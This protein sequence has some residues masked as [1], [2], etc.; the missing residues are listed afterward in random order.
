MLHNRLLNDRY[1]VKEMIGG[2]GMA[3]VYLAQ[4]TILE[5]EVAIKVL[6]LE[7]GND[8]EFIARFHREAQSAISL[9]HPNI[10]NI[11]DVGEE[12]DI[13][14]M[15]MEYVD[16][17]TLKKYIQQNGPVEVSEALQIM[18]QITSAISHA[19]DNGI[20]HRDIKPENILID[21]YGQVKV[22]DFGIAMAL[23]ATALT[24]TNSI[25][26]SVHYL[27]PEQARGG[28]A[29]KKSDIYSLGIVMF[30]L[31]TGRLPFSGQ[32]AVSVALKH[33]Q[34]D[35]PSLRRWN[36]DIPQT[37][38]NAVLKATAKDPFHRYETV[39][40][41][42]MDLE[43]ALDPERFD[44]EPFTLP[45]DDDMEK[46]KA[47]P[48]I[49]QEA[50]ENHKTDKTIIH[51]NGG[52][53][54]K[55]GET[56]SP[57]DKKKEKKKKKKLLPWLLSIL[58]ILIIGGVAA[59]FIVPE[60]MK[61]DDVEMIDVTG[62]EYEEAYSELLK[63]NLDVER[64]QRYSE[65]VEEGIVIS[66]QPEE[67]SVIKEGKTVTVITSQGKEKV[68][69]E[70]YTGSDFEKTKSELEALGFESIT[71][72]PVSSSEVE[73]GMII[74]HGSPL[75][76]AEVVPEDTRVFFRV[77]TGPPYVELE[78]LIGMSQD[79]AVAALKD[80]NL[81][82]EITE[83]FSDEVEKGYVIRHEP[84]ENEDV[85][86]GSTVEL[87]VSKGQEK[88]PPVTVQREVTIPYD[89]PEQDNGDGQDG[90]GDEDTPPE[91]QEPVEQE[92]L[93]YIGDME[94]NIENVKDQFTITE[95]RT[96]QMTFLIAQN[97]EAAYRIVVDGETVLEDTIPYQE[98][99]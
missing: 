6:R 83:E 39:H 21:H 79:E 60:M 19:H 73:E 91:E 64:E 72:I 27:S 31:L 1:R 90:E 33:L 53:T 88:K 94:N 16:G 54:K 52:S 9:A 14:Y 12:E 15:V 11:F 77:S 98:G 74:E 35:T 81:N 87:V 82:E 78:S 69:F 22:T 70:D 38:E 18:S 42:E 56:N 10:V 84:G 50:F 26:G 89:P 28:M 68:I 65:D 8:D 45:E 7:Y 17:M 95:E 34:N 2:G 41:M 23:S 63:L 76:D 48:V 67:G 47:I 36:P 30:E 59:L 44:E 32:S 13:Y 86:E 85:R 97:T 99:E 46:T 49:T 57:P 43:T 61:P 62:M 40:D 58:A 51:T 37:V 71:S 80:K 3:N 20:V 66:T 93:V 5:R 96:Y 92:V 75:A 55:P 24:Q 25:L 29:T 4:D